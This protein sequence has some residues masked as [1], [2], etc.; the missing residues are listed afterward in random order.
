V[1]NT[2]AYH[3]TEVITDVKSFTEQAQRIV[4]F[5]KNIFFKRF[6]SIFLSQIEDESWAFTIK[7]FTE[8][9]TSIS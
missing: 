9:I 1:T 8:V 5:V 4:D 3:D 6:W 7:L 2:L